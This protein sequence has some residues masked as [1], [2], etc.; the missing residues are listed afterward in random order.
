MLEKLAGAVQSGAT[1]L[2]KNVHKNVAGGSLVEEV[3]RHSGGSLP[4][5]FVPTGWT[6]PPPAA[7]EGEAVAA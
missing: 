3:L 2:A 4:I 6:A 1:K 7:A 5:V